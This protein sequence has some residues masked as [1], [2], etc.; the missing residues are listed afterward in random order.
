[1]YGDIFDFIPSIN[2]VILDREVKGF[3]V[4]FSRSGVFGN[5]EMVDWNA[6]NNESRAILTICFVMLAWEGG[7]ARPDYIS[8]AAYLWLKSLK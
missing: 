2:F 3:V 5:D 6:K 8:R 7:L 4:A 1:M